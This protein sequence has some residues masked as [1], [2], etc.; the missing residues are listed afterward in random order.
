MNL[1][2][3]RQQKNLA[4]GAALA[5]AVVGGVTDTTG[6]VLGNALATSITSVA[7]MGRARVMPLVDP[8]GVA[9]VT[10]LGAGAGLALSLPL[11]LVAGAFRK[12]QEDGFDSSLGTGAASKG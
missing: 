9:K 6:Q 1:S 10:L 11:V 7:S 12:R 4:L 5:G 2:L 3:S 8:R